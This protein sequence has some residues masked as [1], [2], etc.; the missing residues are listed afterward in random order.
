M[1]QKIK[2]PTGFELELDDEVF[3]D[4]ELFESTVKLEKGDMT[5][6]PEFIDKI[7]GAESKKSF[8]DHLRTDSG[9]VPMQ[10]AMDEIRYILESAGEAKKK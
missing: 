2:T 1:L 5:E 4:M 8:Y 9:R 7:M 6:L 3:N 10:A